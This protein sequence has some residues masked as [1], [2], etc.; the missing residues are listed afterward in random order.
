[1]KVTLV[2]SLIGL[3]AVDPDNMVVA[4][5]LFPADPKRI[6]RIVTE[7]RGGELNENAKR[8]IEALAEKGVTEIMLETSALAEQLNNNTDLQVS[9]QGATAQGG[10][11]REH[12]AEMASTRGYTDSPED[13]T[14]LSHTVT[15]MIARGDVHTALSSR[16]SLLMPAVQLLE[17]LDVVLNNLSGRMR[18]WYGVHF[19]EM[20][21]RVKDHQDYARLITRYG[22]RDNLTVKILQEM[23]YKKRDSERV[24]E[25]AATSMGATLEEDDL[26]IISELADRNLDLYKY[27]DHLS[28]YI[29]LLAKEI[30]PNTAYIAG[31]VLGAKLIMKAG[32]LRRMAMMPASTIQVLGA[33][34][35]MFR[36]LK[37]NARP[38]KHGLLFQHPYVHGAPRD[39]RGR[40]ARGIAAKIAI[41][42][43]ADWFSGDFIAEGLLEQLK[44]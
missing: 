30:A 32:G 17:E 9:V 35:A 34:K 39:A 14:R 20:D 33:E 26:A 31:P 23:S 1:M 15:S 29:S 24:V 3:F 38:P 4:E 21:R 10:Y 12:V 16:E 27:R 44:G 36:A 22:T 8:L 28:A 13:Y 37:S 18:E 41:A 2:E 6:A 42:A 7:L 43:R 19:P 25:A 11:I 5:S 40:R